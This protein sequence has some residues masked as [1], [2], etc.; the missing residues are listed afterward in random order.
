M[1][2]N[3][4]SPYFDSS[5]TQIDASQRALLD[6]VAT[7]G[8]AGKQAFDAAQAQAAQAKQD[9][10][11]RAAN[12]AALF[13]AGGNDQT[14]LGAYDDRMNQGAVNRA[15]FESGLAQTQASGTSYLEK[16]RASIPVLQAINSNKISQQEAA[17]RAAIAVAKQ[18]ADD[19]AAA[20]ARKE[21]AAEARAN[22]AADRADARAAKTADRADARAAAKAGQ[23]TIN[24]LLGA[25]AQQKTATTGALS[26]KIAGLQAPPIQT[27]FGP[28]GGAQSSKYNYGGNI[29]LP[30]T[31]G[32]LTQAQNT[33]ID[34]WAYSIGQAS[35]MSP[36]KLAELFSPQEQAAI[37]NAQN[38]TAKLS[39]TPDEKFLATM[40]GVDPATAHTIATN[41]DYK[42]ARNDA[43]RAL[44][45]KNPAG[46]WAK[47][48]QSWTGY[49]GTVDKNGNTHDRTLTA[50]LS[51][52]QPRFSALFSANSAAASGVNGG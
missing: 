36:A 25:A 20:D 27:P 23:P 32:Q 44:S 43:I 40:P 15:N 7:G 31:Q 12:R 50:L 14:F 10:T 38:T 9:A 6:A 39:A 4:G 45:G 52:F 41:P 34:Q 1:P 8:T 16:A 46:D 48:I 29:T 51:E 13:G 49:F 5:S 18:K 11:A 22:T 28:V 17:M 33:P 26:T 35:G 21:A 19:A 47:L 3:T 42:N 37:A 24:G 2:N 30:V